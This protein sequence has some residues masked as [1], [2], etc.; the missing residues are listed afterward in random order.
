MAAMAGVREFN[1]QEGVSE[2]PVY[3]AATTGNNWRFARMDGD[4]V[5]IDRPEYHLDDLG[6]ILGILLA[7]AA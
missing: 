2:Q 6:K 5:Y 3:G 4:L 7:M 1:E